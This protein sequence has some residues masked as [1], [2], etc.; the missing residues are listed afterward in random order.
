MTGV[1]TSLKR[2]A[3]S[4][5]ALSPP[6]VDLH[7]GDD[8]AQLA[9]AAPQA[10]AIKL[11]MLMFHGYPGRR[12]GTQANVRRTALLTVLVILTASATAAAQEK[13]CNVPDAA[14]A[15]ERQFQAQLKERAKLGFSV[16]L[17]YVKS[18]PRRQ[19]ELGELPVSVKEK[20]YLD[21]RA[22]LTPG[23]AA[24]RYLRLLGDVYVGW[25][26]KD[27]WPHEPQLLLHFTRDPARHLAELKP[28]ARFPGNLRAD[29]VRYS[30]RELRR[31]QARI[32]GDDAVLRDAGFDYQVVSAD[33]ETDRVEVELVTR[34]TDYAAYFRKRY[35]P[36]R[37]VLIATEPTTLEC[38]RVGSFTIAPD[39]LHLDLQWTTGGGA[40]TERIEVSEFPD[41]VEIGIVERVPVGPR[42][43]EARD[44]EA[45]ATLTAPLNR[46]PVI[47]A[48][49]GRRVLQS[50]PS[51]G[52]PPCPVRA[53][54]T[55]LEQTIAERTEYGMNAD[56][57][58]VQALLDDDRQF[59]EP[60][61]KWVKRLQRFEYQDDVHDYENHNRKDWGGT[62]VV[63]HYPDKPYLRR[64]LGPVAA[65]GNA[66]L[67]SHAISGPLR[68]LRRS[69]STT[70]SMTSSSA[71]ATRATDGFFEASVQRFL[72]VGSQHATTA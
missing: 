71:S 43:A 61:R 51:P 65:S 12:T 62:A 64:P 47:D 39:D 30:E 10:I 67:R 36:V 7:A 38:N 72:V 20:R 15:A 34:R 35:G 17:E 50:G 57:A 16:D 3:K 24:N 22:R 53:E 68:R 29:R 31:V 26:I 41:R 25:T 49:N 56:P 23:A 13:A 59:T 54:R 32:V 5:T 18:L 45:V 9:V 63:A 66:V 48:A 46:R 28:I 44:A 40:V 6:G 8:P 14:V 55:L 42:T 27:A 60:E 19:T 11:R 4:T 52:D 21:L 1:S 33:V 37:T 58:Y 2:I 70:R 69:I